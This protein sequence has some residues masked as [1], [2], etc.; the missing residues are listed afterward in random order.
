MN[1]NIENIKELVSKAYH[2]NVSNAFGQAGVNT[3]NQLLNSIRLLYQKCPPE[4]IHTTLIVV[5]GVNS[6]PHTP[7]VST[8]NHPIKLS[9]HH[10]LATRIL[11]HPKGSELV[12]EFFSN[13][14]I[15]FHTPRS[16]T[17]LVNLAKESIV[18]KFLCGTEEI[19]VK[20][21][22]TLIPKVSPL[23]ASNFCEPT[24]SSLELALEH[25]ANH[26]ATNSKCR[27]LKDIWVGGVDG[28]RL[29][30]VNKPES[31]M[32]DSLA[33]ALMLLGR[34]V[35]VRPEQNTDETKPVDIR[36]EWFGS[37]SS[38]LI[39]VKWLGK[40][41][42]QQKSASTSQTY[43]TYHQSRAQSGADQLAD[44]MDRQSR[45]SSATAPKG[46]LV[47]FDA[48]RRNVKG[49]LDYLTKEDALHYKDADI[50]YNPAHHLTRTDFSEPLR[51][52]ME[53]RESHFSN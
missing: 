16:Q 25:Y 19:L 27:I 35:T 2:L 9:N 42:A 49:P 3:L 28:P 11:S 36:V 5:Q 14:Q 47:V 34:D 15:H 10:D 33:Q 24:L 48:R 1:L 8:E 45:H 37:G 31:Y 51:F 43:T 39:E 22:H 46:Y 23:L 20:D 29:V 12:V 32:R 44:Y 13:G 18:Y 50:T 6:T 40:S 53:P 26:I 21:S 17:N 7:S 38:A 4:A 30:L 41:L 52:F